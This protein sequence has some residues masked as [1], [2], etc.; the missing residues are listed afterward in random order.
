MIWN[1]LSADSLL[2]TNGRADYRLSPNV[3]IAMVDDGSS[4]L[5]DLGGTFSALPPVTTEMVVGILNDG[6]ELVA[7]QVAARFAADPARVRADLD[8]LTEDLVRQGVIQPVN[9]TAS[10]NTLKP[11]ILT[12][13]I[14]VLVRAVATARMKIELRAKVLLGLAYVAIRCFGWPATVAARPAL[15]GSSGRSGDMEVI[16]SIDQ[17]VRSAASRHLLNVACKER[18]LVCWWLLGAAHA[19]ARVVIGIELYPFGCHCWCEAGGRVLT[20]FAD[21]CERFFPVTS[22]S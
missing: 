2:E 12:A 14:A 13:V 1:I 4:R 16:R 20:D 11:S 9:T 18:S 5:L 15:R 7:G 21:R 10:R 6:P 22:Y 3:L 19:P 17:A 8:R